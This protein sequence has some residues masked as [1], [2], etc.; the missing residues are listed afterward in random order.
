MK[1]LNHK[2]FLL[3]TFVNLLLF[4]CASVKESSQIRQGDFSYLKERA[5]ESMQNIMQNTKTKGLTVLVMDS[6]NP[7]FMKSYG[8]ADKDREVNENTIFKIASV[9]KVFTALGILKLVEAGKLKLDAPLNQYIPELLFTPRR[10]GGKQPTIRQ[11]LTHHS[12]ISSDLFN[13]FYFNPENLPD[14][15]QSAFS[16]LPS[17]LKPALL[18]QNPDDIMAYSNLSYSLLGVV[19]ER[20][21]KMKFE[22]FMQ[23]EIFIPL[24]MKQTSFLDKFQKENISKGYYPGIFWDT[25]VDPPLIRDLPAGSMSTSAKDMI[26]FFEM[27]FSDGKYK[28]KVI[29]KE[30]TLKEMYKKQNNSTPFDFDFHIGIPY[31]FY[32]T[33]TN[34]YYLG[35]G[36]DL[37][38]FHASLLFSIEHKVG[39][40][41]M[42]NSANLGSLQLA[43]AAQEILDIAIVT[44]TGKKFERK[45]DVIDITLKKKEQ[46]EKISGKYVTQSGVL[47]VFPSGEKAGISFT[48]LVKLSPLQDGTF[49][50][51]I[52]LFGF[53]P[54]SVAQMQSI[55]VKSKIH[56]GEKAGMLSI[57][58]LD[59][60]VISEFKPLP[61][62]Q[63]W[64]SRV[65]NYKVVNQSPNYKNTHP[66]VELV[67]D[68]S[69]D[70]LYLET[71]L[72][73][74][75]LLSNASLSLKVPILPEKENIA[76]VAGKGRNFGEPIVYSSRDGKEVLFFSGYEFEKK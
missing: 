76:Y 45:R 30:S 64:K 16:D 55:K 42:T 27:I 44:K 57:A 10:E 8:L 6:L 32:P 51:E 1:I 75:P 50:P 39:V 15:Y 18:A 2:I 36:G 43:S 53:I 63:N 65:G 69:E 58:G 17:K 68:S 4:N 40:M 23:K 29:F 25:M 21:S 56:E 72:I 47:E 70:V 66:Y 71:E 31:W 5:D 13:G 67:Y 22:D 24:E 73:Y 38:P 35:H 20:V 48:S 19:I 14:D 61:I 33:S 46:I 26:S 59:A 54:L 34:A 9:S 74:D 49:Q 28:G 52:R 37:P 60:A 41:V 3:F 11:L 12:G 62:P 7:I